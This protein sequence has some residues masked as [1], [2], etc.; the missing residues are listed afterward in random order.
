MNAPSALRQHRS[1]AR[2]EQILA[3]TAKAIIDNGLVSLSMDK[4]AR[5]AKVSKSLIYYYFNSLPDL[6]SQIVAREFDAIDAGRLLAQS[7]PEE[8]LVDVALT[9]FDS[10]LEHGQILQ[11]LLADPSIGSMLAPEISERIIASW[12]LLAKQLRAQ[13]GLSSRESIVGVSMLMSVPEQAGR[14]VREGRVNAQMGRELCQ[15]HVSHAIIALRDH[16]KPVEAW[17]RELGL[18]A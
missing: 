1:N 2:R 18:E 11:T 7:R 10:I 14:L 4:L 13:T 9:Y 6:L 8:A 5:Q 3:D 17:R 16:F 15:L 12:R